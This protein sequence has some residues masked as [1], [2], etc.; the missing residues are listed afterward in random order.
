[1][2]VFKATSEMYHKVLDECLTRINALKLSGEDP[3]KIGIMVASHNE[4]TVKY[5]VRRFKH[6]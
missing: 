4:E 6:F 2:F 1:M 3:Q 5:G